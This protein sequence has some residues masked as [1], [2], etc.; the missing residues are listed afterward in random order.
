MVSSPMNPCV[1]TGEG[2][3]MVIYVDDILDVSKD[4]TVGEKVWGLFSKKNTNQTDRK[5]ATS[6]NRGI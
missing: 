6:F 2:I 5:F 3:L 4:E 1:F